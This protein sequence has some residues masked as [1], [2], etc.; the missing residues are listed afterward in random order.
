MPP[1]ASCIS[2][3]APTCLS[4]A[5]EVGCGPSSPHGRT[6]PRVVDFVLVAFMAGAK[7]EKTLRRADALDV[8]EN[9]AAEAAAKKARGPAH[10]GKSK[11]MSRWGVG[12]QGHTS[13]DS[14][15]ALVGCSELEAVDSRNR[16]MVS[17]VQA[18]RERWE[19]E[20]QASIVF[21]A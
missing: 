16:S 6:T 4:S 13:V 9:L 10:P 15:V 7:P 21:G 20:R 5:L 1:P 12:G 17:E 3:S 11:A 18:E 14:I 8:G 2:G 19:E